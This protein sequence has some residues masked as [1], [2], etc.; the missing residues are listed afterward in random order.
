MIEE[1][2]P[3]LYRIEVPLPNN[4]LK[5]VNSYV[6]KGPDRNLIVDT[7]M[8]REECERVLAAALRELDVEMGETDIF[9]THLHS[10]H[11]GLAAR[12]ASDPSK[13]YFNKP[14][15]D[16]MSSP[17]MWQ[18]MFETAC[19][20]GFPEDRLQQALKRHPGHRFASDRQAAYTLVADGDQLGVG[21]YRFTCVQTPGHTPGHMC[22]Y[23]PDKKL[24]L[25]GDHILADIT[26]NISLWIDSGDPLAAYL[27]SLDKVYELDV[28]MVLP[29][30]RRIF[31]DCRGRIEE[32]KLHHENRVDEVLDIVKKGTQT[33]YGTAGRMTWDMTYE[34]WD[35]FPVVQQ[36]FATGEALAHLKYLEDEGRVVRETLDQRVAF[37][38]K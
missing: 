37:S 32:L 26:P 33:A 18:R 35:D 15:A 34:S 8:N 23:E 6:L 14:D 5:A 7:A 16:V 22:L 11:L 21:A 1:I 19:R 3:D 27:N 30:H 31:T 4:P 12:L 25:A 29:G 9:V 17:Q 24:L 2:L 28:E 20:H 13:V 38:L 10:D 36:W